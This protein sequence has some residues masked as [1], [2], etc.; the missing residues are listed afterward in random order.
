MKDSNASDPPS[1]PLP[2]VQSTD[3]DSTINE[4]QNDVS[5]CC[6]QLRA[7]E[8]RFV[9]LEATI[10]MLLKLNNKVDGDDAGTTKGV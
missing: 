5:E 9:E 6:E 3:K 8:M 2:T 4:L 10:A 7:Y 1:P